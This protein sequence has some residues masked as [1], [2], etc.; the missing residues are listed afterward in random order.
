MAH[1]KEQPKAGTTPTRRDA[2]LSQH[3]GARGDDRDFGEDRVGNEKG[4]STGTPG[5]V[6]SRRDALTA[7]E[8]SP[9]N[10]L[11]IKNGSELGQ[12]APPRR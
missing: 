8:R 7:S 1:Q 9:Q 6:D 3:L 5:V 12:P 2:E 11:C 4:E 10:D